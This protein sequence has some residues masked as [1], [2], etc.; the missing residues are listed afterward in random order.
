MIKWLKNRRLQT[1][2]FYSKGH[3]DIF[4]KRCAISKSEHYVRWISHLHQAIVY[5]DDPEVKRRQKYLQQEGIRPP[6]NELECEQLIKD[7]REWR[8]I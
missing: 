8:E 3:K 6:K 2:I 5:N 4:L 7:L 1:R